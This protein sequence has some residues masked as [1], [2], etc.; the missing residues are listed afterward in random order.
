MVT[1]P[2]MGMGY[3]GHNYCYRMLSAGCFL[4]D[5]A[6]NINEVQHVVMRRMQLTTCCLIV[7][8]YNMLPHRN[9][10][11]GIEHSSLFRLHVDTQLQYTHQQPRCWTPRHS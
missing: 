9:G 2:Y 1:L 8:A 4:Q 11:G 5:A 6:Y 3:M 10:P 7:T